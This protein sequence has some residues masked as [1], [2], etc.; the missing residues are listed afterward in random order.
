MIA[1][2]NSGLR[3]TA[4]DPGS[5]NEYIWDAS[6]PPDFRRNNSVDSRIGTSRVR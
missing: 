6:S 1:E 3:L 5:L 4:F 2:V